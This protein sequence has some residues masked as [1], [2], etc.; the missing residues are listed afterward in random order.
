MNNLRYPKLSKRVFID[1]MGMFVEQ[2]PFNQIQLAGMFLNELIN[3]QNCNS[4]CLLHRITINPCRYRRESDATDL[5]VDC[6][7]Q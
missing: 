2:N 1:A 4:C 5:M 6:Y 3:R 7:L